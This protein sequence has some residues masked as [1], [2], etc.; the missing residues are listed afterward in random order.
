TQSDGTLCGG[1]CA[2]DADDVAAYAWA[3]DLL[4]L[5]AVREGRLAPHDVRPYAYGP[6]DLPLLGPERRIGGGAFD[7]D[8]GLLYLTA[9]GADD[10]QGPYAYAPLV[11][12]LR[13]TPG[14]TPR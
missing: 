4:D 14:T 7:A 3:W 1:Y 8:R 6:L 13:V 11:L 9:L 10:S 5:V 12:A 2:R